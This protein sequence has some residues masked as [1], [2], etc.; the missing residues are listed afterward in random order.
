[1]G[2]VYRAH[3][4]RLDR[5]V[6]VK[7][8]PEAVSRDSD[9]LARF[10]REAK[11]VAKLNHPNILDIYDYGRD[12]DITYSVTEL[13]EGETL[14]ERLFGGALGWRKAAEIG[15]AIADGL[16]AAHEAG[17]VHR[18]LKPSNVFLTSDGRVKVL[19]FGLARHESVQPGAE[20]SD[21]TT[22]LEYTD[23]GTVL[24]TVG[25]MST[26]Q[27]R[28][29]QADHR[30]D[31]FSLGC[32]L[33]EM[34]GGQRA[35]TG[36]SAV[37]TMNAILKEEPADLSAS[38]EALP[39]E[40]AGTVRR[41]L[42]KQPQARF[43][44]ARDLAFALR[45]ITGASAPSAA[46]PTP[47]VRERKRKV[48]WIAV[49]VV[50]VIAV[51]VVLGWM[52]WPRMPAVEVDTA[53]P[54]IVV[55]PF[56]YLGPPEEEDFADGV[57]IEIINRLAVVSGLHTISSTSAMS[58]KGTQKNIR[59]IGEELEVDYALEGE[60]R[61]ARA[62]DGTGQVRITP[63]LIR[64]SDDSHLWA[65]S[66]DRSLDD[67]FE[68]QSDIAHQVIDMLEVTLLEPEGEALEARPTENMEA[69]NAYLRGLRYFDLPNQEDVKRATAM[70]E[71]AVE[72]D[73][74]FAL[75][76]ARLSVIHMMAVFT[77]LDTSE[78][79]TRK[80]Q[81]AAERALE[82]EPGLPEAHIALGTGYRLINDFERAMQHCEVAAKL[83]P[84][85]PEA[86]FCMA[87]V[88]EW[89]GQ[90]HEAVAL[91]ERSLE[92]DPR[93]AS[94]LSILGLYLGLGRMHEE[95]AETIE[96]AIAVAPDLAAAYGIKHQIY[97]S[98]YGP[99]PQS[100]RVLE[101]TPTSISGLEFRWFNQ[102][103]GEGNYEA[104]LARLAEYPERGPL[105][106]A[107]SLSEC[108][109]YHRLNQPERAR[110]ACEDARVFFEEARA[111]MPESPAFLKQLGAAYLGLGRFDDAIR[112]LERKVE[113]YPSVYDGGAREAVE[114]LAWTYGWAG[115]SD[116]AMDEIEFLLSIPSKL[117]V[118]RLRLEPA[119]DP[120]RD[121]P[122]FQEILEKY[123][124]EYEPVE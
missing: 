83:R 34:V 98:W 30:S 92:I 65:T 3:D 106:P 7:V 104:A 78:D 79:R 35:F 15:A 124:G 11:A 57:T 121:H 50:A 53:P 116:A 90:W 80:A 13:L 74:D 82:L 19:D 54:R 46:E 122:R 4:E 28:G 44:S 18:D 112:V 87:A 91:L 85:N 20:E 107:K 95:A 97:T 99:S 101:E 67:I 102:E 37:E 111:G 68:I 86:L 113:S 75:A 52:M 56:R 1:M 89:Q 36:D 16:G 60:V 100:R 110:E 72:L 49:P 5:E 81:Q 8:L 45:S 26:E 120:L 39:P 55:L 31:I 105:G 94:N 108:T 62:P 61:W 9:R 40:L 48:M 96:R 2:E 23:P 41:C 38:G 22:L 123:E 43:Q 29:Q 10:E 69:Y 14:R 103:M 24:G 93:N 6:A 115:Q 51:V 58:Y 66:Y 117:T 42:E 73:P 27:V 21:T 119:W 17:I 12:G 114:Q 70:F 64:V 77:G 33:Y 71:L 63:Q 59:Q 76:H 84:N 25:Y 118:A 88:H 32:V 109:C 47:R